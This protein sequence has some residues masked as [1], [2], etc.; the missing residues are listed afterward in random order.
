MSSSCFDKSCQHRNLNSK[1]VV[2]YIRWN[3][4]SYQEGVISFGDIKQGV[5]L[6]S[7]GFLVKESNTHVSVCV[8][9]Y[10]EHGTFR[11]VQNIPKGMIIERR[12]FK[13]K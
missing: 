9:R 8:D 2:S 10:T 1:N 5:V 13:L 4:A 7:C 3:D 6:E 12:D 11:H